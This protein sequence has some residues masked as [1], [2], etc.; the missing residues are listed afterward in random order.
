M[1]IGTETKIY[2]TVFKKLEN[3]SCPLVNL[4]IVCMI[5]NVSQEGQYI[6]KTKTSFAFKTKYFKNRTQHYIRALKSDNM[7]Y[8]HPVIQ[9]ADHISFLFGCSWR[10]DSLLSQKF[11]EMSTKP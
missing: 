4:K 7:P 11:P 8:R 2:I 3:E 1:A 5:L 10:P 6:N 9:P